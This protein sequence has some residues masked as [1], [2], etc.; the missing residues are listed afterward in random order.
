MTSSLV[1]TSNLNGQIG[2]GATFNSS[3]LSVGVHTITAIATDSGG[4][5]GSAST[6]VTVTVF[7]PTNVLV[8]AGDIADCT[9]DGDEKTAAVLD[10][11]AG[12]VLTLGDSV[13]ENGTATEFAN[14]YD[15]SWGR[16][17]ARTRP[18]VGNH[19]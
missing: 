4:L 2:T 11:I 5:Q 13:Y 9:W 8:A 19:E 7:A 18:A 1:W 12:T 15:P 14:C 17:K 16:H 10:N 3:N 6:T